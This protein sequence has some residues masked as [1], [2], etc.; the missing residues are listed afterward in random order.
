M[1]RMERKNAVAVGD[2]LKE[3]IR[4]NNLA[5]SINTRKVF[6]AWDEA[7]GAGRYSERKF[8]RAGKLYVTVS[9][10]VVRSQLQFQKDIILEKI[11]ALIQ[12]DELFTREDKDTGAVTELIIK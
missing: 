3:Y 2:L 12:K 5:K 9:S 6:E 4:S 11:N 10:S 7:S 1:S 8:F